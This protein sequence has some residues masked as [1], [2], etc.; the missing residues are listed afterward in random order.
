MRGDHDGMLDPTSVAAICGELGSV[1]R[2]SELLE[3]GVDA[4]S[5]RRAVSTG[6]LTRV[7]PGVYADP[8]LPKETRVALRHGG[9]LACVSVA[10]QMGLWVLPVD[11]IVHVSLPAHGH[12]RE[13]DGCACVQHWNALDPSRSMVSLIDALIQIRGCHGEDAFFAALES[14]LHA[15]ILDDDGR[16]G[17]R[18]R[19][20]D[21]ARWLVD[22]AR[23][24]A[25][26]GLESLLRLRLHRLGIELHTQVDIGGVGRVDFVAGDR[27]IIEVD[28]APG[29][30]DRPSRHKD[31]VRDAVAAAHG[32]LTIRFDYALVVH[33]W[34]TVEAAIVTILA[35]GLHVHS[36]AESVRSA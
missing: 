6:A 30:E 18:R 4:R 33:D 34:P 13:H 10:R 15:G 27:L 31:R 7:R 35:H 20:T 36:W 11:E 24:D 14:A 19:I 5:L 22:F 28:G 8:G 25:E 3:R 29:H 21:S 16:I 23:S 26:S 17:L 12:A 1:A 2:R 9:V 32:F